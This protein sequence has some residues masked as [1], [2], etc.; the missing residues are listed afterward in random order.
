LFGRELFDLQGRF[1]KKNGET[2]YTIK[3]PIHNLHPK[4]TEINGKQCE[5][6]SE[7]EE[8]ITEIFKKLE[9]NHLD[10]ELRWC[11]KNDI[12][13]LYILQDIEISNLSNELRLN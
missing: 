2:K 7:F 12:N 4:A 11:S 5:P 6:T 3:K 13:T 1:C 9:I 8:Y 10:A